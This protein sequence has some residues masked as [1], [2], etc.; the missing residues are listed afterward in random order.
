MEFQ[1]NQLI[2][3]RENKS[4]GWVNGRVIIVDEQT[5][6]LRME[7]EDVIVLRKDNLTRETIRKRS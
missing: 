2:R 5:I 1:K 7:T 4:S 6:T 3:Y